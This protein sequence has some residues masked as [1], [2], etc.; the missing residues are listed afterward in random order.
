[1]NSQFH[2]DYMEPINTLTKK[3]IA[4]LLH[5]KNACR[6]FQLVSKMYTDKE[7]LELDSIIHYVASVENQI[8][9]LIK[10]LDFKLKQNKL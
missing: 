9:K 3:Q 6:N 2:E 8:N 5:L 4:T 10:Q 7:L 1:M